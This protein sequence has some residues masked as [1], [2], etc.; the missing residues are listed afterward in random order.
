MSDL[1]KHATIKVQKKSNTYQAI[2]LLNG[3]VSAC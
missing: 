3:N 1:I 2:I